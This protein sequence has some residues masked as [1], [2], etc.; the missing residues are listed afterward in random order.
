MAGQHIKHSSIRIA[1]ALPN[2]ISSRIGSRASSLVT[3][4]DNPKFVAAA[5][6]TNMVVAKAY[7]PFPEG[8]NIRS[9]IIQNIQNK[10]LSTKPL[11][12]NATVFLV[13][14]LATL[15]KSVEVGGV[16]ECRDKL[17]R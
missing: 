8:P 12:N 16:V 14:L 5:K 11:N 2:R 7:S 13:A 9:A 4:V 6:Y 15:A 10:I 17:I 1:N 3:S